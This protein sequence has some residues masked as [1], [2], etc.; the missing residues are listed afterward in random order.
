MTAADPVRLHFVKSYDDRHG[1]PRNYFRRPGFPKITLPR[2]R[3]SVEF[4]IAYG[5]AL[6]GNMPIQPAPV[7]S[8]H[9][10]AR[11]GTTAEAIHQYL[12][13]SG[14][15]RDRAAS[16][17]NRERHFL[18]E[19]A[20]AFGALPLERHTT[21]SLGECLAG[22]KANT[23]RGQVACLRG[24]F[25][26][27]AMALPVGAGLL[28]T[29]PAAGLTKP[30]QEVS[31][32]GL[33]CWE[34][35]EIAQYRAYWPY[36]TI[37]RLAFELYLCTGGRGVDVVELGWHSLREGGAKLWYRPLK[38]KMHKIEC[39]IRIPPALREA[40]D[41]LPRTLPT[42]AIPQ[43]AFIGLTKSGTRYSRQNL[44]D[45]MKLWVAEAGIKRKEGRQL[46]PHGLRKALVCYF[47]A[48]GIAPQYIAGWTGQSVAT[49]LNYGRNYGR[50]DAAERAYE[51]SFGEMELAA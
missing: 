43:P 45:N 38:T 10:K 51:G 47:L 14:F 7:S 4:A 3:G 22:K 33:P 39:L 13:S 37:Q 49:V 32:D 27:A 12:G 11:R 36:G 8:R 28:K 50:A 34:P 6:A 25:G 40:L 46:T 16:T 23:V 42:T 48:K 5:A 26:W 31:E 1:K 9:A 30:K 18:N 21:K 29:D 44:A 17:L 41:L 20:K 15:S 2:D 35:E 19:F 24:F